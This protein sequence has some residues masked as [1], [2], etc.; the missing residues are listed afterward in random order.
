VFF[1]VEYVLGVSV[2]NPKVFENLGH[3]IELGHNIIIVD[4]ILFELLHQNENKETQH[5]ELTD[6][7]EENEE[8]NIEI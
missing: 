6:D 5:G 4:V 1:H 3:F 2:S 7:D 8:N